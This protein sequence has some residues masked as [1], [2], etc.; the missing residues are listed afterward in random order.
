MKLFHEVVLDD[1]DQAGSLLCK[2]A[3]LIFAAPWT[4]RYC[5]GGVVGGDSTCNVQLQLFLSSETIQQNRNFTLIFSTG[6]RLVASFEILPVQWH[7]VAKIDNSRDPDKSSSPELNV[8]KLVCESSLVIVVIPVVIVFRE[9]LLVFLQKVDVLTPQNFGGPIFMGPP[10]TNN[11]GKTSVAWTFGEN[12][13]SRCC[14]CTRILFLP[15][16]GNIPTGP[17]N[18]ASNAG[19]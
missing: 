1:L 12:P 14:V 2:D 3:G 18:G 16:D 13:S 9:F 6:S 11:I 15:R 8:T 5:L 4:G 7:A 10:L 17:P 19:E